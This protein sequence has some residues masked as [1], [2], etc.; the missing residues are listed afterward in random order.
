[1][2]NIPVP[3]GWCSWY[4]F[5]EK[6]SE[7]VLLN[8]LESMKRLKKSSNLGPK[9]LG[10]NLFQIDDGYQTAWG[11][12][13]LVNKITFPTQSLYNI[14]KKIRESK[15]VGGI[16]MAPFACDKHS[17]VAKK[18]PSWILKKKN[19]KSIPG[20]S[21]NCGKWFY[22]LDITNEAVQNHVKENILVA[23][24]VWGFSYLKL[25]FLYASVLA[26][27]QHSFYDR[28]LSKAQIIQLG[29]QIIT[30]TAGSN[31]FILGCGAPLGSVIGLV[32]ANRISSG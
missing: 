13:S 20:N 3:V 31:I 29:M 25:D 23:L 10:F 5:F 1:L 16:W 30:E 8:N 7:N 9:R 27:S 2:S 32:H 26:G 24:K 12:W 22:G 18:N 14:V 11:D 6:I 17:I 4:H 15:M 28:T 21:A 19:S